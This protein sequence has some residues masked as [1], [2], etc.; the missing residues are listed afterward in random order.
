MS[1]VAEVFA[2]FASSMTDA[3]VVGSGRGFWPTS[4]PINDW[5]FL[6]NYARGRGVILAAA[7]TAG[8]DIGGSMLSNVQAKDVLVIMEAEANDRARQ[9]QDEARGRSGVR[10]VH[11]GRD[12]LSSLTLLKHLRR[13]GIVALK[14][15]RA[16]D[17]HAHPRGYLFG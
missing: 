4:R 15:D 11:V 17:G 10:V 1:D 16:V 14:F 5:Q 3:I 13:G 2:N 12:P 7:Q 9:L 8:W 6:S